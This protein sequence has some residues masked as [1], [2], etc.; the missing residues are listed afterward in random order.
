MSTNTTQAAFAYEEPSIAAIL[1]QAGLLLVLNIVNVCL[2]KLLYCGLIGQVFIGILWGSP[3]AKWLS[4]D[5]EHI[6]QQLGYLGLIMLVYEGGLSMSIK[7]LKANIFLS[8]A[9]ALTGILTPIALSFVLKELVSASSLQ[10]FAA[11]AALSAT[12]LGTTFTV[13]S[14]TNMISTRLGTVTTC[15]A[16]LD[17]V[18][19]LVMVQVVANLGGSK[20]SFDP[21]TVIRPVFVSIGFG[22]AVFVLCCFCLRPILKVILTKGN[23]IPGFIK[24]AQFAF[25]AHT[26]IVVGMVAGATYAGTSSLFAAYLS[27]VI[28]KWFDEFFAEFKTYRTGARSDS[29][30]SSVNRNQATSQEQISQAE[31]HPGELISSSA[32]ATLQ[33]NHDETHEITA[34]EMIYEKHYKSPVDRIL[35]PFFFA[36]IGFAIPIAQMFRGNIVWRGIVYAIFMVFG[37]LVTGLWLIRFSSSPV[38]GL[39]RIPKKVFSYAS[40]ACTGNRGKSKE[41]G[42]LSSE[43]ST[44]R[45][46]TAVADSSQNNAARSS[47][48]PVRS[49]TRDIT[50]EQATASP[51]RNGSTPSS[52]S[53]VSLSPKPKS[54]YPPAILGLAM[55]ARGEIGYLIASLA[56]S[57]GI[58]NDDT[59]DGSSDIYLVVIWA[60]SI[61]T[62]VG[63][64]AVGTLTRRVKKLQAIRVNAGGED[65][66][67]VWGI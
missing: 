48:E 51:P 31:V 7:A 17:D 22:A 43:K 55:I 37:K 34:G 46:S 15:A 44:R 56:Q 3:G 32:S 60:I 11:G 18:V 39:I 4:T 30:Q 24:T 54:L 2:D 53:Q 47:V 33:E 27:G 59:A 6:I 45:K 67:G 62:L 13:L 61:C 38:C 20:A 1:N 21:I 9:V 36:S 41:Q 40:L 10:A 57:Q 63:P 42:T 49:T 12:S 28:V 65:P 19:G 29:P 8:I 64:I 25:L 16:M 50:A 58:F 14:T 66:L 26:L 5:L 52:S 35:I 23:K